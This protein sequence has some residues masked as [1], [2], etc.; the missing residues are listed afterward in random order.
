MD[1]LKEFAAYLSGPEADLAERSQ[2]EYAYDVAEFLRFATGQRPDGFTAELVETHLKALSEDG[3]RTSSLNRK[4]M[5]IRA[6]L[7]FMI[8]QKRVSPVVLE[9][10]TPI[11][12]QSKNLTALT[13]EEF[14]AMLAAI[15]GPC[16]LRDRAIVLLLYAAGLRISELCG[17]NLNQ[18]SPLRQEGDSILRVFGKRSKERIVLMTRECHE[19]VEEYAR[20]WRTHVA[21]LGEQALFVKADGRRITRRSVTCR[22]GRLAKLASVRHASSHTLRRSCATGLLN[23]GMPIEAVSEFLGHASVAETQPYLAISLEA[24]KR[25]HREHFRPLTEGPG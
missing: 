5:A 9:L 12:R 4:R 25:T 14:A 13:S 3:L 11:K 23:G 1:Y 8:R 7:K 15:K 19:A 18:I 22:I 17:L 21:A 10:I 16:A 24:L 6:F 20:R 2:R